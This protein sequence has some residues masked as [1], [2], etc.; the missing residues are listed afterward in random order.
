MEAYAT[1]PRFHSGF[2]PDEFPA[3]LQ[4]GESV[5]TAGQTAAIG[6]GLRGASSRDVTVNVIESD[7][8]AGTV[9]RS[10]TNG[11]DVIDVFVAQIKNAVA[12]DVI[13]GGGIVASAFE[14]T[15]RLNRS[16]I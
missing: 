10:N 6:A 16:G 5:F 15:Y 9:G 11:N 12:S 3:I 14:S 13:H 1:A 7:S 4:R 2:L 8:K